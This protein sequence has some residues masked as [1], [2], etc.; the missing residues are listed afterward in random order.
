MT[1]ISAVLTFL[2]PSSIKQGKRVRAIQTALLG[3]PDVK[4][5][6]FDRLV[7]SWNAKAARDPYEC[8]ERVLKYVQEQP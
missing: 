1:A 5:Q 7:L 6:M 3:M 8:V 4:R 2:N